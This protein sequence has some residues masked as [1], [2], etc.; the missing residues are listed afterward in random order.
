MVYRVS[1]FEITD[2]ILLKRLLTEDFW[3]NEAWCPR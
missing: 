3:K 2:A 1:E